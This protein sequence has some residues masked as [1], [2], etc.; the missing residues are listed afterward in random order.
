M[1]QTHSGLSVNGSEQSSSVQSQ[2]RLTSSHTRHKALFHTGTAAFWYRY[3]YSTITNA[4]LQL[5]YCILEKGVLCNFFV[6][7]FAWFCV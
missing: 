4:H 2:A 6:K 7:N 5:Q 1:A 3:G